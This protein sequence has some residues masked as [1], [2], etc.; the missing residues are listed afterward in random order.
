M[1]RVKK[2]YRTQVSWVKKS[3]FLPAVNSAGKKT[4]FFTRC[5]E[6]HSGNIGVD[7][8]VSRR[9]TMSH[10]VDVPSTIQNPSFPPGDK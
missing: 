8:F 3:L 9:S 2:E 1:L 10:I 4:P 6:H 7:V 5:A